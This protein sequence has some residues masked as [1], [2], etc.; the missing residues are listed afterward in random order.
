MIKQQEREWKTLKRNRYDCSCVCVLIKVTVTIVGLWDRQSIYHKIPLTSPECICRRRTNLM[1]PYSGGLILGRK[2]TSICN[3]LNLLRFFLISRFCNYQQPLMVRITSQAAITCSKSAIEKPE[4][5][6]V[7]YAKI[8]AFSDLYFLVYRQNR[9]RIFPCFIYEK[10]RIRE[11]PYFGIFHV[12]ED[13]KS[14]Q[15]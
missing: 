3:L 5:H 12:V 7:K 10:M 6:C 15:S 13:V 8:Q 1:G 4:Q 11:S 14:V 2:N 9:I